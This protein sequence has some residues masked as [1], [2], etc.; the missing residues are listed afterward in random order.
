MK[1]AVKVLL[2]ILA[3]I[4]ALVAVLIGGGWWWLSSHKGELMKQG[5]DAEIAGRE[6]A[7]GHEQNDCLAEAMKRAE[8]CSGLSCRIG[9][10]LFSSACIDQAKP[11]AAFCDGVPAPSEFLAVSR[12]T[13]TKC[14]AYGKQSNCPSEVFS[15]VPRYCADRRPPPP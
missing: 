7:A 8:A 12:W 15:T 9:N 3:L 11:S 4:V 5:Q 6:F 14:L 13:M 1:P 10:T 2:L